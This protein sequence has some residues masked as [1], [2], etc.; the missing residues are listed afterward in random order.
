MVCQNLTVEFSGGLAAEIK[1]PFPLAKHDFNN[2][3]SLIVFESKATSAV[4]VGHSGNGLQ[5]LLSVDLERQFLHFRICANWLTLFHFFLVTVG[6]GGLTRRLSKGLAS[7]KSGP[8]LV[9]GLS[10]ENLTLFTNAKSRYWTNN[11][12]LWWS[13]NCGSLSSCGPISTSYWATQNVFLWAMW[14]VGA[15]WW[16]KHKT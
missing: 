13:E 1:I 4:I 3:V 14:Y 5:F 9:P 10:K 12:V 7:A 15:G 16:G 8:D 11:T 2:S 6:E